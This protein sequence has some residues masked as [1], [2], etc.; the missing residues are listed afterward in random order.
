MSKSRSLANFRTAVAQVVNTGYL[1]VPIPKTPLQWRHNEHDSVSNHPPHD[2]LLNRS[3]G[4]RS[5]KTSK[6]RSLAFVR[7]IHRR[8]VKCGKCFHLMKSSCISSLVHY[9]AYDIIGWYIAMLISDIKYSAIILLAV[10]L[11]YKI[12]RENRRTTLSTVTPKCGSEATH[13]TAICQYGFY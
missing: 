6:L 7:G 4:R 13:I 2:C 10:A 9:L 11:T 8:P 12:Q 5:K 3:F 1:T